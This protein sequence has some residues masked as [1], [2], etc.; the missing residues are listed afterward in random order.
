MTETLNYPPIASIKRS[1][2]L[3]PFEKEK[4]LALACPLSQTPRQ[5]KPIHHWKGTV[6][7]LLQKEN[8][9]DSN[10]LKSNDPQ[11]PAAPRYHSLCR[12]HHAE[13]LTVDIFCSYQKQLDKECGKARAGRF[14]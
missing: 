6:E 2:R 3:V 10:L 5:N 14:S 11:C 13:K 12:R 4:W 1:Q 8:C 7:K 9:D